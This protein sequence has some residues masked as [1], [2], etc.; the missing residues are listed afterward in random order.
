[1][2]FRTNT[3]VIQTLADARI[4]NALSTNVV[5][6]YDTKLETIKTFSL[7]G[8]GG[9]AIVVAEDGSALELSAEQMASKNYVDAVVQGLDIKAS[10]RAATITDITLSGVQTVDGVTLQVGDRILVK[11]QNDAKTNG[12]YVVA[13]EAWTRSTDADNTPSNEVSG[14][15]FVFVEEGTVNADTGWVLSNIDGNVVLG[16]D[17]LGFTQFSAA[18]VATPG[19]GLS[20]TG[21]VLDVNVDDVTVYI[22]GSDKLA[23]KSSATS[24]QV[25][26]SNGSGTAAWG[27]IDLAA[28]NGVTG[29]LDVANGGTGVTALAD[30]T[31][32][33]TKITLT[34]GT[35]S[36]ISALTID[37]NEADLTL[38]NIGGTLSTTKGGTGL[39]TIGTANQVLRV[40]A[41]GTA[42][43]YATNDLSTITGVLAVENGGTGLDSL[44]TEGQILRVVSGALSWADISTNSLTDTDGDTKVDVEASADND[45]I[46]FYSGS[47]GHASNKEVLEVFGNAGNADGDYMQITQRSTGGEVQLVAKNQAGIGNVNI[48]LVPQDNGQVFIGAANTDGV[49]Q[50]DDDQTL[51]LRGGTNTGTKKGDLILEGGDGTGAAAGGD[52]V[53]RGGDSASGVDGVIYVQTAGS[54]NIAKFAGVASGVNSIEFTNAAA[55]GAVKIAAAGSDSN[56]DVSLEPKGMGEILAPT[57][58][59][60]NVVSNNALVSKKW[61]SDNFVSADKYKIRIVTAA[62]AVTVANTDHTIIVNKTAG[63]ATTVN[64]PAGADAGA[65]KVYVIKDGKGDAATNNIT[66]TP[67]GSETIDGSATK[68]IEFGYEATTLVFNGT[69]WNI[70]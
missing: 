27:A 55:G 48:R 24:G 45:K 17:D 34:G 49:I 46:I 52:I 66:I 59:E 54:E 40:N 31:A 6:S 67:N 1:M 7:T 53:L 68:V 23:I 18:G 70:V 58:Y 41:E 35:G 9:K 30:V 15:M 38:D 51:T 10:V 63:E 26:V 19:A 50:A 44:G 16:T 39:A 61:V 69:Q 8:N 25:L 2:S 3:G 64:L 47:S 22:D 62:G 42:L 43:E 5:Q 57:G 32:A 56:I 29:T 21:N 13:S 20:K 4:S 60:A 65:G 11:A 12:I 14:G 33:S 36:V 28:D 37:V